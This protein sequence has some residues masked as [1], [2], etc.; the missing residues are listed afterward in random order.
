VDDEGLK[1]YATAEE[2]IA[3]KNVH[4]VHI[5]G[6]DEFHAEWAIA[7]MDAG[8]KIVVCEKPMTL[9]LEESVRVLDRAIKF[10]ADG[11]VFMT[12][13]NYMGHAL[14]RA[15]RELNQRGFFG[16]V[17]HVRATYLQD[18]LMD[19]NFWNWRLNGEM[20][21]TKDI[22]PHLISAAYFMGG[23]FPTKLTA[24]LD[25]IIPVRPKPVEGGGAKGLKV[26]G[27]KEV[28]TAP[29]DVKSDLYGNVTCDLNNGGR[30]AFQV[31]QYEPG[32]DNDWG[33]TV[34]GNKRRATWEQ[35]N[36]NVLT[37]GQAVIPDPN[38]KRSRYDPRE[39]ADLII[40]NNPGRLVAIG[41][42]DAAGYA[43]YPGEH[44]PGH[45]DAFAENFR[46]AYKVATG[47]LP[48][49]QAVIPG[50]LIGHMCVAVADAVLRSKQQ[51]RAYVDV[52]YKGIEL[53][54]KN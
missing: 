50:A 34:S 16:D 5:A 40:K 31:T 10:E 39:V 4:A 20:C 53:V 11:G 28:K 6:P 21:A 37:I 30:G 19:P 14:P 15:V 7:A 13:I 2:L 18:W 52:D 42:L 27:A 22:L 35:K 12:N 9:T 25:T 8:K 23:V 17:H 3:D 1:A 45:I 26:G 29:Y 24:D 43:P 47:Q 44:P 46:T 38:N 32:R 41:C 33:I 51:N 49:D 54:G 48:R 36:P